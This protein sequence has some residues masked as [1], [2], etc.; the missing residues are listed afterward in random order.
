MIN[1]VGRLVKEGAGNLTLTGIN[2]YEGGTQVD[3]GK[4]S[5]SQDAN[6]G[7]AGANIAINNAT[8]ALTDSMTVAVL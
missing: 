8:L 4:L 3:A 6:L 1:G 2:T 5:I 7:K